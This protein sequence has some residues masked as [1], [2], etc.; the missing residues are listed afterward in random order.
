MNF[1]QP[2]YLWG[3]FSVLLP[4]AIHLWNKGDI[5]TIKIGSVRFLNEQETKQTRQVKLNELL[6]LFLRML[7]LALLVLAIAE[8][9]F[10]SQTKNVPLTYVIE[11]SLLKNGQMDAFLRQAPEVPKRLLSKDF[12]ILDSDKLQEEVPKYWQ[13]AQELQNLESDSIVVFSKARITGIQG[14][15]PTILATVFWIVMD[16]V[17]TSDSLVS[18]TAVKDGV[19]TH[20]IK[21]EAS[22]TDVQNEF[23]SKEQLT[24]RSEDSV[25]VAQNGFNKRI[26]LSLQ[27]TLSIGIYYDVEF[28]REKHFFAAA[29]K[30]VADFTQNHLVL[31]EITDTEKFNGTVFDLSVWLKR[32]LPP[33]IEGKL[34]RYQGDSLATNSIVKGREKDVFYLTERLTIETVLNELLAEELLQIVIDK[35]QLEDALF[36]LDKRTLSV[37]DFLPASTD[38]ASIGVKKQRRSM[39]N[40]FWIAAMLVLVIERL[41]A[42]FR[43]Q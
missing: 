27:D 17:T 1:L 29:F 7:M 18:A 25:A 10:E 12:P 41:L 38:L 2:T 5:K 24:Y 6:L 42:K 22:Y 28:L 14:M 23:I 31:K 30:A 34:L 26:P 33:K 3:L 13:L 21:S 39:F 15:R 32:S 40:W 4:L 35:P 37:K 19:L 16:E 43:K 36:S 8:P 11:P 9:E 20:T